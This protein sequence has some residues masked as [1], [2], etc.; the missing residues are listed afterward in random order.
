MRGSSSLDSYSGDPSRLS[1][2]SPEVEELFSRMQG[3]DRNGCRFKCLAQEC[4]FLSPTPEEMCAHI[5]VAHDPPPRVDCPYC[6]RTHK[7]KQQARKLFLAHDGFPKK[8]NI[9]YS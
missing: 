6:G 8:R 5:L 1:N 9:F 4:L 3:Q 2:P 7:S